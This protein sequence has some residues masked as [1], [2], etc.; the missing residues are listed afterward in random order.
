[1]NIKSLADHCYQLY[2]L[3][4][5]NPTNSDSLASQFF[6]EKK[7]IGSKERKLISELVFLYLRLK[8]CSD[9]CSIT[10]FD[11][12]KDYIIQNN[13][14]KN[15]EKFENNNTFFIN[16][17]SAIYLT[18]NKFAKLS[19]KTRKIFEWSLFDDNHLSIDEFLNFLLEFPNSECKT[20]TFSNSVENTF[21][22]LENNLKN[23]A[24]ISIPS[25]ELYS[26]I[27]KRYS[28]PAIIVN[29]LANNIYHK[30]NTNDIIDLAESLLLPAP[31]CIRVN[32]KLSNREKIMKELENNNISSL[33]SEFSPD[34]IILGKRANIVNLNIYNIGLVEIQ[35]IGSQ[36]IG[37]ALAPEADSTV[38]DA[39]AGA[40][41]KTLHIASMMKDK[42]KITATDIEYNRLK[43]IYKRA[44]RCN[45]KS[46]QVV[47]Q[48]PKTK[49]DN[50]KDKFDYV[51]I[52][53]PCTGAGTARRSP[54]HKYRITK[55]LVD[56][57]TS[58][59]LDILKYY[60]RFVVS[61]GI[62][63]YATCSFLPNENQE[64]VMKFLDKNKD[65]QPEPL[66]DAFVNQGISLP[67]LD[68]KQFMYNIY[69][70]KINS[71]SFFIA[72]LRKS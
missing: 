66:K 71:D 52:D 13:D 21:M 62:L 24:T 39:C 70:H 63:L 10:N 64:I 27:E 54:M 32:S 69:T 16:F 61:G 55:K 35:D 48:N 23:I 42:G 34:G 57:I 36:L 15:K 6:R 25:D 3:I 45:F 7:Y 59:Q 1:M 2:T 67:D 18:Q 40:G 30:L 43:E 58:N 4:W 44:N 37:Y 9:Y 60:S 19:D 72:K 26:A 50:L 56:K 41:G 28:F 14:Y 49:L 20:N 29:L 53:A 51:L 65:F 31:F 22:E 33:P 38:L 11:N 47:H 17:F 68:D 46:I 5:K 12:L 8:L